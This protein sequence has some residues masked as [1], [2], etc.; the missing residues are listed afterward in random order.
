[1]LVVEARLRRPQAFSFVQRA[2]RGSPLLVGSLLG[3]IRVFR[4]CFFGARVS[5]G[6]F[7]VECGKECFLFRKLFRALAP[8]TPKSPN[9]NEERSGAKQ[10][11]YH[12]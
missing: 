8:Q 5:A 9:E 3:R 6:A 7:R 2:F 12:P 1:M 4:C 11:G 10:N